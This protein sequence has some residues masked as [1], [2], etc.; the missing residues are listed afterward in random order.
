MSHEA[1]TYALDHSQASGRA[2]LA[3]IALADRCVQRQPESSKWISPFTCWP[4]FEQLAKRCRVQTRRQV[5]RLLSEL[6]TLGEIEEIPSRM[7]RLKI[8]KLTGFERWSAQREGTSYVPSPDPEC[9]VTTPVTGHS[10]HPDGTFSS[11][12]GDILVTMTGHSGDSIRRT[13]EQKNRR[14]PSPSPVELPD[15]FP[16]SP[17]QAIQWTLAAVPQDFITQWWYEAAGAGGRDPYTDKPI[18][19]F[20]F[21]INAKFL[22]FG[23]RFNGSPKKNGGRPE[24]ITAL[25]IEVEKLQSQ[26]DESP[27][28]PA[29]PMVPTESQREEYRSLRARHRDAL[30][31]LSELRHAAAV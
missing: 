9:P 27:G 6:K 3:L 17:E 20:N 14:E 22:R 11:P 26:I 24:S 18:Q 10:R 15:R 25:K 5:S 19:D 2:L 31:R 4:G 12:S 1:V 7:D 28:N 8:Y 13:E 23:E 30:G 29:S 16:K 21:W